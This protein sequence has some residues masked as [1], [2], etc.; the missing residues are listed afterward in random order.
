M[1]ERN[2]HVMSKHESIVHLRT[3]WLIKHNHE[4]TKQE[5]ILKHKGWR[6]GTLYFRYQQ[7]SWV[8]MCNNTTKF[9]NL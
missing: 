3:A 6:K 4:K 1:K 7:R 8:S 9:H 2:T 5:G